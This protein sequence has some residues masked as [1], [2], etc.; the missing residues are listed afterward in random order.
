MTQSLILTPRDRRSAAFFWL[1]VGIFPVFWCWFILGQSFSKWQSIFAIGWMHTVIAAFAIT[2][3]LMSE[4]YYLMSL[5][6][7]IISFHISFWLWVWL[8]FRAM[9]PSCLN[10]I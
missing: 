3:P 5:R 2:W 9:R 10:L 1:G 7:P 8:V 4:R 6:L